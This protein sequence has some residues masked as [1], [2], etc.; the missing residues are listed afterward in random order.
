MLLNRFKQYIAQQG[1]CA[2]G[3]RVLLAVSG[4]IDSMVMLNLFSMCDIPFAVAHCNF[5]LRGKESDDDEVFVRR[6]SEEIGVEFFSIQFDT[7]QQ[8]ELRGDSLQVVAR[9][10]RY[11]WF[12]KLA[13]QFGFSRIAL[14]HNSDDR[15]ET[16]FINLIRGTGIKGL[17]SIPI[18]NGERIRP[19]LFASRADIVA[20]AKQKKLAY[21]NDSSNNQTKYLRNKLRHNILPLL[22]GVEPSFN[23]IMGENV[24]RLSD[25][26]RFIDCYMQRIA[27]RVQYIEGENTIIHLDRLTDEPMPE[28]ILFNLLREHSFKAGVVEDIVTSYKN[29]AS[30]KQFFSPSHRALLDRAKLHVSVFEQSE[31]APIQAPQEL[32]IDSANFEAQFNNMLIRGEEM[33]INDLPSLIAPKNIAIFDA[34]KLSFPIVMRPWQKGDSFVP[35]G[36]RG[37]KKISNYLIDIK[38]SVD[39]KEKQLVL[40]SEREIV[41]LVGERISALTKVGGDTR[42]VV[43]ITIEPL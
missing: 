13:K 43:R 29:G 35:L 22:V 27:Q 15:V 30:G 24:D 11:E 25:S 18:K 19:L 9:D 8:I 36:M 40:K 2:D 6:A 20:H 41:W 4:G 38:M 16:F 39:D 28:Y 32:V 10:L 12:D 31:Q 1:L 23:R 21:R 37:R 17:T 42:R 26:E 3:D 14:A 33:A 34:D 7:Q 5:S